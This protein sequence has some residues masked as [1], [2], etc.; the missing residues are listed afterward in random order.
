MGTLLSIIFFFVSFLSLFCLVFFILYCDCLVCLAIAFS[1]SFLTSL[2]LTQSNTAGGIAKNGAKLVT[3]V[4][5]AQV[6]KITVVVGGSYG[7]G[8]Y[9]MCGRAYDP[10]FL[11][12]WPNARIS[13]MGGE[14][15]A[16][17]L[18]T[19]QRDNIEA[20]GGV[21]SADD[22]E[23]FKRPIFEKYEKVL[24]FVFLC[25]AFLCFCVFVFC[26]FVFCVFVFLCFCVFV[27]VFLC[28]CVLC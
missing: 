3:A 17:V 25:F 21:W 20:R 2:S 15:A 16:N 5:C 13:V 18:A 14:Q 7:A 9:G 27:F 26:V 12:M 19:V 22:E 10:R 4:S 23:N 28:F 8:N 24:C 6:P 1:V 11:F